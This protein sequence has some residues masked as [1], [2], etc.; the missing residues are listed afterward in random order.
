VCLEREDVG[1]VALWRCANH[2][3]CA[4]ARVRDPSPATTDSMLRLTETLPAIAR[5]AWSYITRP[6]TATGAL[7]V[8][9]SPTCP[10]SAEASGGSLH[11]IEPLGLGGS[12]A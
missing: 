5:E 12:F 1:A 10:T 9:T 8:P 3:A 11:V 6:L 4:V 2:A 7:A